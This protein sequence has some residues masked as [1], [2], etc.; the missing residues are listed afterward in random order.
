VVV[1]VGE[2]VASVSSASVPGAVVPA[3][4]PVGVA[5]LVAVASASSVGVSSGDSEG[6]SVRSSSGSSVA[7]GLPVAVGVGVA[8]AVGVGVAVEESLVSVA[9]PESGTSSGPTADGPGFSNRSAAVFEPP[10]SGLNSTV[11]VWLWPGSSVTLPPPATTANSLLSAPTTVAPAVSHVKSPSFVTVTSTCSMP[12]MAT[13]PKSWLRGLTS[14]RLTVSVTLRSP[15]TETFS[16][17]I[18]AA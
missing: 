7:V 18:L 6:V 5:P 11:T 10:V 14:V 16:S 1:G 2:S 12:G 9:S 8:V 17:V 15:L 13:L 4:V 3:A